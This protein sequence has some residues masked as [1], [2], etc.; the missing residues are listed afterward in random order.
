MATLLDT[1]FN[2]NRHG[3]R[4]ENHIDCTL[5]VGPPHASMCDPL[6]NRNVQESTTDFCESQ[7]MRGKKLRVFTAAGK[8][9]SEHGAKQEGVCPRAELQV[10]VG[11]LRNFST[12]GIDHEQ[13]AVR[14]IFYCVNE[15]ARIT[16]AMREPRVAAQHHE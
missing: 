16:K 5:H 9:Q 2:P 13:M 1:E 14:V 7:G 12:T 15:I 8:D 4:G 3:V 11:H 10:E 6:I